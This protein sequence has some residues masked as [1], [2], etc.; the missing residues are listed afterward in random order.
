VLYL[1]NDFENCSEVDYRRPTARA[2]DNLGGFGTLRFCS[3][4]RNSYRRNQRL[5]EEEGNE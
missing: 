2:V 1:D 3:F 4:E 5:S